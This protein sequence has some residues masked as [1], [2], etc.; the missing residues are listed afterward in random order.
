MQAVNQVNLKWVNAKTASLKKR[1][2]KC[3]T[4]EHTDVKVILSTYA[5]TVWSSDVPTATKEQEDAL[6]VKVAWR[7]CIVCQA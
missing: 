5:R 3:A 6:S 1:S 2:A 4:T 7:Y